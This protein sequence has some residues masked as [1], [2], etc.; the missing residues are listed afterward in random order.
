MNLQRVGA[1]SRKSLKV[2][3]RQPASLFM[4]ILFPL[5]LT[6]VFGLSFGKMGGG[7]D[8]SF[9]VGVVDLNS[10]GPHAQWS[11]YLIANMSAARVLE[12]KD[13]PD[14]RTGQGDLSEGALQALILIP[15]NFGES[16][17]SFR[18]AMG[19]PGSWINATVDLYVDSGSMLAAQ[20]VPSIIQDALSTTLF[21]RQP[22][23]ASPVR[24]G[25]PSLVE[26]KRHT[27]YDYFVPGLF[28]FAAIFL[29][30]EVAQSFTIE[31]ER[32]LLRRI[33]TTPTR[34]SEVIAAN[35]LAYSTIAAVQVVIV[36][37]MAFVMGFRPAGNV[38][39]VLMGFAIV[40]S[41]AVCTVGFGL[42]TASLAKDPGTATGIAFIFIMPLMFLG[43]F[44]G[45]AM[46]AAM[47]S[48]QWLVPSWY[49]TDAMT[50]LFLRGADAFG[51][52]VLT[53]LGVVLLWSALVLG[54]GVIVF[55][56]YGKR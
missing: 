25:I 29:I 15:S 5:V 1:L 4:L 41:F 37:V 40:L 36:F 21:G 55:G 49:V 32:G 23:L 35:A 22:S 19:D 31:R 18:Q 11:A 50:H 27:M 39:S 2:I 17:N 51:R 52:A 53:D 14:N 47:Q 42:I 6:L 28:A 7:Q 20:A 30:M 38:L 16:C 43:T 12:V 45:F 44:V 56:R 24:L 13:Y 54:A 46:S 10:G 26:A 8:T 34:S 3:V 33:S 48:I 9:R